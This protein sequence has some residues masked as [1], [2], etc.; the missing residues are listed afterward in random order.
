MR[1]TSAV[2][3]VNASMPKIR[4]A[5]GEDKLARMCIMI[6]AEQDGVIRLPIW[7]GP[8]EA[9]VLAL[10]LESVRA[11]RPFA[12]KLVASRVDAAGWAI[13]EARITCPGSPGLLRGDRAGPARRGRSTPGLLT[14]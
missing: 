10:A 7:I 14:R 11:P 13:F 3:A 2:E 1:Q 5:E 4:R 8:T 9:T 6:R 12:Y